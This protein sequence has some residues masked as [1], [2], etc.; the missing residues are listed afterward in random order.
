MVYNAKHLHLM[1][2]YVIY[3]Y[4]NEI[5]FKNILYVFITKNMFLTYN[6]HFNIFYNF[7]IYNI[8]YNYYMYNI[9]YDFINYH[10]MLYIKKIMI[11]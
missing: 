2:F 10:H 4:Y 9:D 7:H 6:D 5:Y 3:I 1:L 11:N 8:I